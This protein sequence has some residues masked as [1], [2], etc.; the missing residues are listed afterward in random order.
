MSYFT[1]CCIKPLMSNIFFFISLNV[2]ARITNDTI[3]QRHILIFDKHCYRFDYIY[4]LK[5]ALNICCFKF[6]LSCKQKKKKKTIYLNSRRPKTF[7]IIVSRY[8]FYLN[9]N[10][11]NPFNLNFQIGIN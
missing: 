9:E 4:Q 10:H 11:L 5:L 2:F 1:I 8:C 7:K 3:T 6:Y